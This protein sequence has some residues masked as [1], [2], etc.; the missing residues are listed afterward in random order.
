MG[1]SKK[2][3]SKDTMKLLDLNINKYLFL[4]NFSFTNPDNN[5]DF[6]NLKATLSEDLEIKLSLL[7]LAAHKI[8]KFHSFFHFEQSFF[9]LQLAIYHL[10]NN[11][12]AQAKE[13]L[14][15]A[16]FQ[17][18]VNDQAIAIQNNSKNY[19][20]YQRPYPNFSDY[21]YFA[22]E[23]S[24]KCLSNNYW[25]DWEAKQDS[26]TIMMII[27][28]IRYHHLNY[29][30]E[31]AKL[32]LN[33]A[34]IFHQLKQDALAKNDLVKANNLDSK[35]KEKDY[36]PIV[37][38]QLGTEVVLGLGS[39]LGDRASYLQST[40]TKLEESNIL[41]NITHSSI[42]QTK[43]YL[44]PNHPPEWDLDYL[45]MAIKG[46]T[47]LEPEELLKA[48]K[49]VEHIIGRKDF[50]SWSPREID[51]DI[52]TYGDQEVEQN[53]LTI[54]HIALLQRPWLIKSLVEL[55][56]EWKYPVSGPYYNLTI[57]EIYEKH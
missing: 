52:L 55:I 25:D 47:M 45:N 20:P 39:N 29:H 28:K 27:E 41:Y 18:H 11:E 21:L 10:Q 12:E 3:G 43:A 6:L 40:I 9:H 32:Y 50:Q 37:I 30:Q 35:L 44:K 4:D 57:K 1:R 49:D 17:D 15:L 16:I 14:E 42:E 56:P 22:T 53:N 5:I 8:E 48:I 38:S 46:V 36:Y 24:G 26:K 54:P 13:Q 7:N 31:S 33:R 23:E 51:I 19:K 34:I 2:L